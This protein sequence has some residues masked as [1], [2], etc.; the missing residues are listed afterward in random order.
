M[1]GQCLVPSR[2]N[3]KP[4]P[5]GSQLL[6]NQ[7]R[8]AAA[9]KRAVES[10]KASH[11]LQDFQRDHQEAVERESEQLKLKCASCIMRFVT[12]ATHDRLPP[13]QQ[14]HTTLSLTSLVSQTLS[15][16]RSEC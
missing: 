9:N 1:Q 15:F 4:P 5:M 3:I 6:K 2:L 12:R 11:V 13:L 14:A 8:A 10:V 16:C 7:E